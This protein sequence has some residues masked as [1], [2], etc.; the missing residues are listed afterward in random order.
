MENG[1]RGHCHRMHG[2][3]AAG[4]GNEEKR[5]EPCSPLEQG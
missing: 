1:L 5:R 2:A 3:V 4:C